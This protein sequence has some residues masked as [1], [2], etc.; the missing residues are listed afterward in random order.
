MIPR[1]Q[2]QHGRE[3]WQYIVGVGKLKTGLSLSRGTL[4]RPC[5]LEYETF[6]KLVAGT[7]R[8]TSAFGCPLH[9]EDKGS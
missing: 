8:V 9:R 3:A 6:I 7:A 5:L 4:D 1:I 2:V